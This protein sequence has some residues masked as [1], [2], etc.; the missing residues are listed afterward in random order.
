MKTQILRLETHDDTASIRDKIA[1]AKAGRIL[2]AFP[3]RRPPKLSKLD[4]ILIQRTVTRAGAQLAIT[5]RDP[6]VIQAAGILDIPVFHSIQAAQRSPWLVI[7][8]K[9]RVFRPRPSEMPRWSEF[10]NRHQKDT[11]KTTPRGLQYFL[12]TLGLAAFLAVIA[13]F[14]PGAVIEV[15]PARASQSIDLMVYPQVGVASVLPGGQ[16][17]AAEIRTTVSGQMEAVA[18]GKIVVPDKPARVTLLLTNLTAEAVNVPARTVFV[19]LDP[20]P[21]RFLTLTGAALPAGVGQTIEVQA[22]AELPGT[23]D[24][25]P[26]GAIRAVEGPLGL[27][28][29]GTNPEPAAGGDDR[30]GRSASETDYSQLYDALITSLTETA[31]INLQAQYGHDLMIL[32]ESMRVEQVTD[33]VRQPP[34]DTPADRISLNL[35]AAISGLAVSTADLAA[36]AAP[37][38]D[39]S[40]PA[41]TSV[42]PGSYTFKSL[43]APQVLSDGRMSWKIR[44]TRQ[45]VQDVKIM[46]LALSVRGRTVS[47]VS[48]WIQTELALEQPPKI[49]LFPAWL[50]RL[51]LIPF[52]IEVIES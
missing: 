30:A 14:V 8:R 9:R 47:E 15:S 10:R 43:S 18:T 13:L 11:Q 52:R 3:K 36:V 6:E 27:L 41:D 31:V 51:P 21:V 16:I 29:E 4:F 25:V 45:L 1:W 12:F 26:A 46:G 44:V 39:A 22:E 5:T 48:Q 24:N 37:A 42:E 17:P 7:N 28:V 23:A 49:S 40:L 35:T 38:L 50:P 2:L 19:T 32:S 33:E 34:V 20:Q